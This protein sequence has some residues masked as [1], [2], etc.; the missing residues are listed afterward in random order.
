MHPDEEVID[1][2]LHDRQ[3]FKVQKFDD[4]IVDQGDSELLV[5]WEHHSEEERTWGSLEEL[6]ANVS[7]MV[8]KYVEA[9]N[10]G[11]DH[12]SAG[13]SLDGQR[14]GHRRVYPR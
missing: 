12:P 7:E 10:A 11:G 1:S 14:S 9:V 6:L 3:C 2:A 5:R 4:W 13:R 8:R